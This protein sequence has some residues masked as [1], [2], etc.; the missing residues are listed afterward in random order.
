MGWIMS[1]FFVT[2]AVF[3]V[4][5]ARLDRAWGTRRSLPFFAAAWSLATALG[6]V[7]TGS[8]VLLTSRLAMGAAEAGIFPAAIGAIKRWFPPPRRALVSGVL[9]SFMGVGGAL[10]TALSGLILD[11]IH[12]RWMFLIYA[13][14]GLLWAAG[15]AW[16][17]RNAPEDHPGVN[18]A[19]LNLIRKESGGRESTEK[20]IPLFQ[21]LGNRAVL[22]LAAQQFLRAAGTI[23][24]LSWFPTYLQKTRGVSV[25]ES[26]VLTS[27]PHWA[28][29]A[30]S[31][32]GGWLSDR[33][34]AR[35]G[36]LRIARQGVAVASLAAATALIGLAYPVSNPLAAVA[37]MSAGAFCA[38][39]AGPSA[40]ALTIDLGG[41]HTTQVF[42]IMNTSGSVGSIV[43]P[44][45]AAW[46]VARTGS[47][48]AMLAL[49]AAIYLAAAFSWLSFDAKHHAVEH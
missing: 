13:V 15:F 21:L 17:Y 5:G 8:S 36:S 32:A 2:Y 16:W 6:A 28:T 49:F 14:P 18:S 26:G 38:A 41:R 11:R 3:Q 34:L 31:L 20:T 37:V 12:W 44:P 7:A 29:M 10:G 23:F 45:A 48:D 33:M 42:A 25:A 46:L 19:E 9:G 27:L 39:L 43:F 35:T 22:G 4:P 30:G 1:A 47:W 40:Y 24:F